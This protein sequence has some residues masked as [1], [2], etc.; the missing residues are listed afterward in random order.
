ME[1]IHKFFECLI[2]IT[3]CNLKCEYCYV[4]Q[5]ERR[6]LK[7]ANLQYDIDTMRLALT[8][9]RL[10]GT[11][12]FSLCGAGETLL[13][14][15]IV[16]IVEVLLKNGHYVNI[17][18]NGTLPTRIKEMTNRFN[19]SELLRL[20]FS[21]SF[22]YIELK[23]L[24]LINKFFESIEIAKEYNITYLIQLNLYDAYLPFLDDIADICIKRAGHLP[25]L[26]LTRTE[27]EKG[28][29]C[30]SD[31]YSELSF[32]DYRKY[33]KKFKSKLFEFTCDNFM[34]QRKEF[35]YAGDWSG[36]LDLSTG[37]LKPC[38]FS[39]KTQNIFSNIDKKIEFKAIGNTCKSPYCS[40]SSHFIA[41]GVIPEYITPTY[42]E[43]RHRDG[44]ENYS[45]CMK[46]F[47][48]QKLYD[49]NKEYS[50]IKKKI[51]NQKNTLYDNFFELMRMIK[52]KIVNGK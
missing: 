18:T 41:L 22:H 44:E 6:T 51:I 9:Q 48:S 32:D 47:L 49:N 25:Q 8:K 24:N 29:S 27:P 20:N 38:Y 14:K 45:E 23:R 11:C 36:T 43:L 13:Q 15:E 40:N 2:P 30:Q 17:T 1:K 39:R 3:Q 19:E 52:G 50:Y 5:E 26:A 34:I 46:K 4:I 7:Q 33:G 12:Y 37:I 35:C 16:D 21:F 28:I 31:I 42:F 10:G